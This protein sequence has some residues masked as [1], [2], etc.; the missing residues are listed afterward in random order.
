[1]S[2]VDNPV[3][4]VLPALD[5]QGLAAH[6]LTASNERPDTR[7][8]EKATEIE[9]RGKNGHRDTVSGIHPRSGE[10]LPELLKRL[11]PNLSKEQL[12]YE[13][14]QVLK[15][16]RDY[17]NDIGLQ[18]R[19]NPSK[20]VYLTSIKYLDARGQIARIE[21]P[22]GTIT[23]FNYNTDGSLSSYKM[24]AADGSTLEE[25]KRAGNDW[26]LTRNGKTERAQSIQID[27]WGNTIITN[28]NGDQLAHLTNGTDVKTTF[29]D[30]KPIN[31]EATRQGKQT[32]SYDY[33]YEGEN[34]KV[35]ATYSDEPNKKVLLSEQ[36]SPEALERLAAAQGRIRRPVFR[37]QNAS[38]NIDLPT[39]SFIT[40]NIIRS[41]ENLVGQA[42]TKFDPS[43]PTSVGCA[44]MASEVLC[45]AGFDRGLID[46]NV[47]SFE[48]KLKARN[49]VLVPESQL[50]S[51]DV[52][53]AKGPGPTAGHTAI[54]AGN[55]KILG[56]ST[57][58]GY[59]V[60]GDY[61]ATFGGFESR[62]G[63]RYVPSNT[64]ASIK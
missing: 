48:E 33:L 14:R 7:L 15:Y 36:I 59:F 22:T 45:D 30:H 34:V 40:Q 58:Q 16:N 46:A 62:V 12:A 8:T 53:I 35:F 51:G 26:I 2:T 43:I 60:L 47:D 11:H 42:V 6:K 64:L 19:L 41:A 18:T 4:A 29:K 38:F 49:F 21:G 27:D 32:A 52:I 13:V 44:R 28:L 57:G 55:G 17:G 10:T 31:S 3:T 54:Y 20:A 24:T 63:Y 1:M 25:A 56:N 5:L 61:Q 9:V 50:K 23:E 37:Q 39:D